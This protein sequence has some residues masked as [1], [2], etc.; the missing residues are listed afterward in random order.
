M[1]LPKDFKITDYIQYDESSASGLIWL[2]KIGR[3]RGHKVP[4]DIAGSISKFGKRLSYW[5]FSFNNETFFNHRYIWELFNDK[6]P[7]NMVINHKDNNSLN[8]NISNLELVTN[9]ENLHKTYAHNKLGF[10]DKNNSGYL[11]ISDYVRTI[12]GIT[13]YYIQA[14]YR[15]EFGKK[16]QKYFK[17]NGMLL[18][19]KKTALLLAET[20]RNENLLRLVNSGLA[21]YNKENL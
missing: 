5:R 20:W 18:E 15:N 2:K 14:Q 10:S 7:N 9:K 4:F 1:T 8:N 16:I 11:G 12:N 19:S 3:G 6:I 13:Y 17:Y 21:F